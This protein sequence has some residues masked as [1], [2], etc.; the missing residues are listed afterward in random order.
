M[1]QDWKYQSHLEAAKMLAEKMEY[2]LRLSISI[3]SSQSTEQL[4][5]KSVSKTKKVVTVE[6]HSIMGGLGSAVAEVLCGGAACKDYAYRCEG[7]VWRILN[8]RW[9]LFTSMNWMQKEFTKK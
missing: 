8:W 4:V 9:S 3:Q 2:M 7:P 6:E 5:V 1:R